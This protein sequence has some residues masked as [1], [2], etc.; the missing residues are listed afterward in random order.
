[1]FL[2][3]PDNLCIDLVPYASDMATT[4]T[5]IHAVIEMVLRYITEINDHNTPVS[6]RTRD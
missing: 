4:E 1:M 6:N 3:K 2:L 5:C